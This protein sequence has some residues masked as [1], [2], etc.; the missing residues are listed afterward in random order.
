VAS[1]LQLSIAPALQDKVRLHALH[2]ERCI[3]RPASVV[4]FGAMR[5]LEQHFVR[6]FAEQKPGKIAELQDAR[7][8]YKL[9]GM[10]PTRTRP[11]SEALF[12]RVMKGSHLPLI[13]NLVDAANM[14]SLETHLPLGLYDASK[15][16]GTI[17]LRLGRAGEGYQGIRK[18]A[19][20]LENRLGLFDSTGAFGSPSSDSPRTSVTA[21]TRA[22]FV[23]VYATASIDPQRF[24]EV[25]IKAKQIF[26][27]YTGGQLRA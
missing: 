16:D 14:L 1:T 22:C 25:L 9:A 13:N 21:T 26:Y 23:V 20:H 15:I 10:D 8:L 6:K 19:V 2:F 7:S 3:V 17:E 5:E 27:R 18:G 12:R 24:D 4:Q 11:S